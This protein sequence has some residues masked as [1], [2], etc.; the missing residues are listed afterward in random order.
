MDLKAIK[1]FL[2]LLCLFCFALNTELPA[3]SSITIPKNYENNYQV[4][5]SGYGHDEY[6]RIL[7]EPKDN[8]TNPFVYV[9]TSYNCQGNN[10]YVSTQLYDKIYIFIRNSQLSHSEFYICVR[11]RSDTHQSN[12]EIHVEN[13]NRA[14]LPF[15]AQT[16]Y[17]ISDYKNRVM[18]FLFEKG[19]NSERES[20]ISLFAKGKHVAG[21]QSS[22]SL[23][24]KQFESGYVCY[25][26]ISGSS[27]IEAKVTSEDGDYVTVG[28]VTLD[29]TGEVTE[30]FKENHN[31][32]T[33]ASS[34]HEICLKIDFQHYIN[35]I[36]GKI[37]SS[38]T[39]K[40]LYKDIHKQ[41]IQISGQPIE[42]QML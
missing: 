32:I 30:K 8:V 10:L 17:Y 42:A 31:E 29:S 11:M 33:V 24:T 40:T 4:T 21:M 6:F 38:F 14:R 22:S 27:N 19:T 12:Y 1:R 34:S 26:Q 16:S 3:H 15:N 2:L 5:L 25:G 36:T 13:A 28:S 23:T 18:E 20:Q 37:Y 7:F 41:E 35:H 39:A 9:S